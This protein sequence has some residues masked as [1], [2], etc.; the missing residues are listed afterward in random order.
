MP[1]RRREDE[2]PTF[3]EMLHETGRGWI[4]GLAQ[5]LVWVVILG[6]GFALV[7]HVTTTGLADAFHQ[8]APH[9]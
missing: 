3:T 5:L 9:P 4:I 8:V 1:R 2:I 6:G 7:Y